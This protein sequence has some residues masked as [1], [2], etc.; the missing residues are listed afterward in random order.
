MPIRFIHLSFVCI[1]ALAVSAARADLFGGSSSNVA[2]ELATLSEEHEVGGLEFSPDG[3]R[4]IVMAGAYS[5]TAHV[6]DWKRG[7]I[8]QTLDNAYADP[9]ANVPARYSPDGRFLARCSD[10]VTIWNTQS[11]DVVIRISNTLKTNAPGLSADVG[12][13]RSLEF[14]PDGESLLMVAHRFPY[15]DGHNIMAYDTSTWK[16][17]WSLRT[18]PF[19]TDTISFSPDGKS[20][21]I[22]GRVSNVKLSLPKL[23]PPKFGNPPFPDTGLIAI[24]DVDTHTISRTISASAS[25]YTTASFGTRR[26]P[27][28][29]MVVPMV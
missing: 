21:A 23:P 26:T 20:V 4:L 15:T 11:W 24:V 7:K 29:P 9:L 18:I 17:R 5:K 12:I 22:G 19:Y 14:S 16:L 1:T 13:C 27:G 6:W 2:T 28:S 8:I 10:P 3:E 25:S